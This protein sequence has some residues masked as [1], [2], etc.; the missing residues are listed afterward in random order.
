MK[1]LWLVN[2]VMPELAE[3]LGRKSS[4]FGG[5]LTGAMQAV[6]TAGHELVVVTT[7]QDS[8]IIGRY[9]TNGVVYHIVA[10]DSLVAME[11]DFRSIIHEELPTVIHIYGTE[12]DQSLAMARAADPE[13]TLVTVQGLIGT[14]AQ[15]IYGGVPDT[16]ARD[17]MLHRILRRLHKGGRSLELQKRNYELRAVYE[18]ELLEQVRYVNGG[19]RWAEGYTYLVNPSL[20][21]LQCQ[22]ILRDSFYGDRLWRSENCEKHSIMVVNSYAN[23]IKGFDMMLK[24]LR[25]VVRIYPET[26]VYAVGSCFNYRNYRGLRRKIM[27]LAPDYEWYIQ[28]LLEQYDLSSHVEFLGYLT[29][30]QMRERMLK[31]NVFVSASAIEN[32]STSLGEAMMLGVPSIASCVGGVQ[33]MITDGE[34]GFLYPFNEPYMLAYGI[35]RLFGDSSLAEQFSQKGHDHAARTYDREKNSR[36]LLKMYESIAENAKEGTR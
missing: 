35:C 10:K 13:R 14:C 30:S 25:D 2:I 8:Q 32:Q 20:K 3:H 34:D 33:Q 4:V 18:R 11:A 36:D 16:V 9:E 7:S 31:S 29:E 6:R 23:P 26:K 27:N 28:S 5:W 1:I 22:L 15:Q 21:Q 24:A 12:F 19:S 17:T